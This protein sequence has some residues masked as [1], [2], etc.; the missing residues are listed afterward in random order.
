MLGSAICTPTQPVS[1]AL[2]SRALRPCFIRCVNSRVTSHRA[3]GARGFDKLSPNGGESTTAVRGAKEVTSEHAMPASPPFRPEPLRSPGTLCRPPPP[4]AARRGAGSTLWGR[5]CRAAHCQVERR[6]RV[7]LAGDRLLGKIDRSRLV[8]CLGCRRRG[9]DRI[10][11]AHRTGRGTHGRL[12]LNRPATPGGWSPAPEQAASRRCGTAPV[13]A[14]PTPAPVPRPRAAP[15][16]P[17]RAC[18]A[19][20]SAR[21]RKYTCAEPRPNA[22]TE[23]SQFQ[24]AN[25]SG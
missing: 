24:S 1:G 15:W 9:R 18:A 17:R 4:V 19:R 22:P 12:P 3:C 2:V 10:S 20:E 6:A 16:P 13:T 23:V 8:R 7:F 11:W 14:P 25:C 5:R 21:T